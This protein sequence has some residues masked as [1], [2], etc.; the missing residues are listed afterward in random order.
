VRASAERFSFDGDTQAGREAIQRTWRS[1]L[2]GRER[3]P[4]RVGAVEILSAADA[5][6]RL[7]PPPAR[8]APLAKAGVL[9]ALGDV[10]G[11]KVVL[12]LAREGGRMAV[13]GMHD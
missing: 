2:T 4:T 8:I 11:R 12:F 7:G 5:V 3:T 9:V 6:A 1:I 10:G 13:L